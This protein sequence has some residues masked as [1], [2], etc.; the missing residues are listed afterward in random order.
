MPPEIPLYEPI[1][2]GGLEPPLPGPKPKQSGCFWLDR[3]DRPFFELLALMPDRLMFGG[4]LGATGAISKNAERCPTKSQLRKPSE[5][6]S[7]RTSG[8]QSEPR[9]RGVKPSKRLTKTASASLKSESLWGFTKAA[10]VKSWKAS[11]YRRL[12]KLDVLR[13]PSLNRWQ[14]FG[15]HHA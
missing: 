14:R 5:P 9:Q 6:L 4:I 15:R 12:G 7:G 8:I 11:R 13:Y 10:L 1:P 3:A 2:G